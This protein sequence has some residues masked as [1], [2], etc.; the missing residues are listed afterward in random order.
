MPGKQTDDQRRT[1]G[2]ISRCARDTPT[3]NPLPRSRRPPQPGPPLARRHRRPARPSGRISRLA[4]DLARSLQPGATAEMLQA[5]AAAMMR[6]AGRLKRSQPNCAC[7][8]RPAIGAKVRRDPEASPSAGLLIGAVADTAAAGQ[9]L[10]L[11]G[12][13]ESG[14]SGGLALQPFG[15]REQKPIRFSTA[16]GRVA[17][18]PPKE[19]RPPAEIVRMRHSAGDLV[20]LGTS[21]QP[22]GGCLRRSPSTRR[23]KGAASARTPLPPAVDPIRALAYPGA[24]GPQPLHTSYARPAFSTQIVSLRPA[25]PDLRRLHLVNETAA[26]HARGL[27]SSARFRLLVCSIAWRPHRRR[28][29]TGQSERKARGCER[30]SRGSTSAGGIEPAYLGITGFID[31]RPAAE[32]V[33]AVFAT[34]PQ[35]TVRPRPGPRTGRARKPDEIGQMPSA[36]RVAVRSA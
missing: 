19:L 34:R 5:S 32:A 26:G 18:R 3:G 17:R 27:G 30:R 33:P 6:P 2:P 29:S 22:I 15:H 25:I 1:T 4:P 28:P 10:T 16:L 35:P 11:G 12:L 9:A 24:A 20:T 23:S 36:P 13:G 14:R 21:H 31:P 7:R 8:A